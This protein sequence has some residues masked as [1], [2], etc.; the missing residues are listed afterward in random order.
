MSSK[1]WLGG[2]VARAAG[3]AFSIQRVDDGTVLEVDIG[4][5]ET[6][7]IGTVTSYPRVPRGPRHPPLRGMC[8]HLVAG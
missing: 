7:Y 5:P 1:R 3:D 2:Q 4:D 6:V 8:V